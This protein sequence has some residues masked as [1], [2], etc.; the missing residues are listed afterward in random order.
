MNVKV[1]SSQPAN[2]SLNTNTYRNFQD[3]LSKQKR[4]R[5]SIFLC[6]CSREYI[7]QVIKD[8]E[9]D[10][11]SDISVKVLKRSLSNC[12]V[13]FRASLWFYQSLHAAWNFSKI[14]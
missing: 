2:E 4:I 8:F 5:N 3:F 7:L 6:Q 11:A 12:K 1:R 13:S 14:A 9:V 10:K